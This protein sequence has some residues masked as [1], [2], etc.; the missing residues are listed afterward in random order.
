VKEIIAVIRPKKM[1]ATRDAL[2]DLGFPGFTALPVLGRGKQRGILGEVNVE[3]RPGQGSSMEMKYVPKRMFSIVVPDDDADAV[4]QA[5]I[6]V[7]RTGEIGDGRIFVCPIESAT[8]IR[9]DET[10]DQAVL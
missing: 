4:A 8:R 5:I 2:N 7:N 9:T 6:S 10:G 1:G 3:L